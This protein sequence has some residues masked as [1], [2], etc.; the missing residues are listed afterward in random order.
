MSSFTSLALMIISPNYTKCNQS[1][2]E[3]DAVS[4][5]EAEAEAYQQY[6]ASMKDFFFSQEQDLVE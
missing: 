2:A 5:A 4:Q 6:I 3:V 1:P